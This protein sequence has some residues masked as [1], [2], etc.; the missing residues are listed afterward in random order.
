MR[1]VLL[2][3]IPLFALVLV[4]VFVFFQTKPQTDNQTTNSHTKTTTKTNTLTDTN[5]SNISSSQKMKI[6]SPA[7]DHKG[8]IPA[9]FT[10]D[11][12]N[13]NPPLE[14]SDIPEDAKSLVLIMDDPD[15]P[16]GLWV[17]WLLW[18]ISPNT[19]KIAENTVPENATQGYT[20]FER[21]DYGGPCPPDSE[22]RYFF[23]LYALNTTLDLDSSTEKKDLLEEI[24]G[25][26]LEK[27]EIYGK[28]ARK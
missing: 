19:T 18:N 4:L 23:R 28:Y 21:N 22:H 10:C 3:I 7:F 17:H 25:H 13:V 8:Q 20:S 27:A 24:E 26:V 12:D 15:A 2:A 14:F 9:K 1:K 5:L 11:G 16:V 6:S